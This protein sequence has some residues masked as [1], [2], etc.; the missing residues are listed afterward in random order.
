MFE[1]VAPDRLFWFLVT[2][3][4]LI[5]TPGPDILLCIAQGLSRGMSGVRRA[6]GGIALGYGAHAA[7]AGTGVATLVAASPALFETVRWVGVAYLAW[8]AFGMLRSAWRGDAIEVNADAAPLSLW[9]GFL[10]AFLN[11]RD[12]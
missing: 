12:C 8:L 11:P 1:H 4:P 3:L 6:V 7:L 10:T 5:L 2:V 9:R